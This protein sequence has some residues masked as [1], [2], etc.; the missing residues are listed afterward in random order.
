MAKQACAVTVDGGLVTLPGLAFV[1]EHILAR[2]IGGDSVGWVCI[3][4]LGRASGS[5]RQDAFS[6]NIRWLCDTSDG[7][8]PGR[9]V[10]WY[11][12]KMAEKKSI[13]SSKRHAVVKTDTSQ[14]ESKHVVPF[15]PLSLKHHVTR[16]TNS[17]RR[18]VGLLCFRVFFRQ[19]LDGLSSEECAKAVVSRLESLGR[20]RQEV[21]YRL[22]DWIFS[23]QRYW[24]EVTRFCGALAALR[25][26]H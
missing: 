8:V 23:R 20:G 26:N 17:I 3:G 13:F 15:C 24:G 25:A 12:K 11:E 7:F 18:D 1:S 6:L 10:L 4:F 2:S 16:P 22:R 14:N 5:N 21:N 9:L 19:G